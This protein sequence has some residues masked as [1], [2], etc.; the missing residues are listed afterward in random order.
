MVRDP[1]LTL[2]YDS[3]ATKWV[4]AL[5]L[6]NGRLGAMV[7]GGAAEEHLQLN[8]TVAERGRVSVDHLD[9]VCIEQHV[10]L[11]H[12]VCNCRRERLDHIDSVQQR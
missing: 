8:D 4:E 1:N 10:R 6:G 3:S 7:F 5:P 2:S 9:R 12:T 11:R